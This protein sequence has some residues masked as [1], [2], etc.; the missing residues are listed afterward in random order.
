MADPLCFGDEETLGD[1]DA[2]LD[3][4]D[5]ADTCGHESDV[6]LVCYDSKPWIFIE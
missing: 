5:I 4:S 3:E 2:Y 1:C 6:G